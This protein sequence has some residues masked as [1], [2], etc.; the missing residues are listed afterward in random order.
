MQIHKDTFSGVFDLGSGGAIRTH[1]LRV[2]SKD[3]E[4]VPFVRRVMQISQTDERWFTIARNATV[5]DR[6]SYSSLFTWV[7]QVIFFEFLK[8]SSQINCYKSMLVCCKQPP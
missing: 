4:S 8:Q 7:R 2:M 6:Y 1:D 3:P 5:V